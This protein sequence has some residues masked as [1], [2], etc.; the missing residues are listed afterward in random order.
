MQIQDF[1]DEASEKVVNN[2]CDITFFIG[3]YIQI[4]FYAFIQE[5]CKTYYCYLNK[6]E[7]VPVLTKYNS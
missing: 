1:I 4:G 6:S 5:A 7:C 3:T 2:E